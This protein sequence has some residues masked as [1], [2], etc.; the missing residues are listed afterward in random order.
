MDEIIKNSISAFIAFIGTVIVVTVGYRQ[1][2][3]QQDTEAKKRFQDKRKE[4]YEKLWEMLEEIH[5]YIRS[6]EMNYLDILEKQSEVNSFIIKNSL[7]IEKEDTDITNC[8]L[9]GVI[10]V[11]RLIAQSKDKRL[12]DVWAITSP[13]SLDSL[14]E[15]E[16]LKLAWTELETFREE[17]ISRFQNILKGSI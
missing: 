17:T 15:Y 4:I 11:S 10:W 12:K 3:R 14:D 8:Y 16:Q 6:G 7:Y 5:I 2:K 13:L 9:T 1:W